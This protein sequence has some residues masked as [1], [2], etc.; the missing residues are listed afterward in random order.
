MGVYCVGGGSG[1]GYGKAK[2]M[3]DKDTEDVLMRFAKESRAS[4]TF[5]P[6]LQKACVSPSNKAPLDGSHILIC[7]V[8]GS[9]LSSMAIIRVGCR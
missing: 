6:N 8:L 4:C 7:N 9:E 2:R 5:E 1:D 3:N